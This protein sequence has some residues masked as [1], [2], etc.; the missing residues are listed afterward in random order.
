ME[1]KSHSPENI[2]LND[3]A[4]VAYSSSLQAAITTGVKPAKVKKVIVP[5][6]KENAPQDGE[7]VQWGSDNLFPQ[8]V[9]KDS[10]KNTIIGTTLDKMARIAYEG[11]I[12]YGKIEI[13]GKGEKVFI[14]Q[15]DTKVEAFFR[16]SKIHRYLIGALRN[17][18]WFF[19]AFPEMVL[20]KDR[21]EIY[22]IKAQ[23]TAYCR[24]SKPENGV[25]KYCY[26]SAAWEEAP[27][28]KGL[29]KIPVIDIY[30][31]PQD[32][33]EYGKVYNYIYPISYPTEN[34]DFY[35]LA[36]WNSLR[37][38]GWLDVAQS[39]PQFKKALFKNQIS[40]KYM[41]SVSSHWWN[42]KYKGFDGFDTKK[43]QRLMKE[44][45]DK[46]EKFMKGVEEAGNSMMTTVFSDPAMQKEY[47]GWKV[48]AID[49][50]IKDGIYIEDSNEASSHLLFAL[51]L[52]DSLL[53]SKPGSKLGAGS[54]SDMRV[55]FNIYTDT[56]RVHQDLILEPLYFID[57]YNGYGMDYYRFRNLRQDDAQPSKAPVTETT[58]EPSQ[59]AS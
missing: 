33:K 39:I 38:S 40:I 29:P 12:E 56:I 11:G 22:S 27:D 51:G 16:R 14:E 24:Y 13:N 28:L 41:I 43:K 15:Y 30:G 46:F 48:T 52:H 31:S 54:G 26:L 35:S 36:D 6:S 47:P 4:T 32:L 42:W 21:S 8:T 17:F 57:E 45:L 53:G 9:L 37:V 58:E 50:K 59:Q 2:V 10:R 3:T 23:K 1:E 25:V 55:A 19:N 5:D 18:Y 49:N 34:E 20:T 7:I 44:E